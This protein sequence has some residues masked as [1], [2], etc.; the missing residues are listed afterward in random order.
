MVLE[1]FWRVMDYVDHRGVN[2]VLADLNGLPEGA[3][4]AINALIQNIEVTEPPLT[5]ADGVKKLVNKRGQ[6]CDGFLEFRVRHDGNQYRPIFAYGPDTKARQI[7]IFAVA[8]EQNSRLVPHGICDTC[9]N[10]RNKL[11]GRIGHVVAHDFS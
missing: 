11:N 3:H 6:D 2:V 10:R 5:L 9:K 1:R 4:E 8:V 7:T